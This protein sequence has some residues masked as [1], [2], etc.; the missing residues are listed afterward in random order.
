MKANIGNAERMIRF[1]LGAILL[2]VGF[3]LPLH[4]YVMIAVV[5]AGVI[6]IITAAV[7]FCPLWAVFG[8]NTCGR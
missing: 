2:A 6:A 7:R 3:Y 5:A 8:I 4:P 1:I